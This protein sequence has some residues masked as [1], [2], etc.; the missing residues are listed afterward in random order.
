MDL[1]YRL[2]TLAGMDPV[3]SGSRQHVC[4]SELANKELFWRY[5]SVHKTGISS[6][7]RKILKNIYIYYLREI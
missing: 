3:R 6:S 1:A 4:S 5:L 2:L 7:H